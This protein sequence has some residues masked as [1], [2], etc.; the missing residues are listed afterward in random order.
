MDSKTTS[1]PMIS[2]VS[3]PSIRQSIAYKY[4]ENGSGRVERKQGLRIAQ[5]V[6]LA[7][8]KLVERKNEHTDRLA[9]SPSSLQRALTMGRY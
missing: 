8:R 3:Q 2:R 9:N 5:K 4:T 1:K 6:V 7:V